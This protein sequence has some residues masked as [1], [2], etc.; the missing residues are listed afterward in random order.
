MAGPPCSLFVFMSSSI[1][2]RS[3]N[4]ETGDETNYKVRMANHIVRNYLEALSA[5]KRNGRLLWSVTEQPVSSHMPKLDE[6]KEFITRHG[7]DYELT[8]MGSYGHELLKPTHLYGDLP[9]LDMMA[10]T[11]PTNFKKSAQIENYY[12]KDSKGRVSGAKL[13]PSSAEYPAKFC[14]ALFDAWKHAF[15]FRPKA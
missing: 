3:S 1:H 8:F 6:F 11:R 13:L 12:Y 5:V 2:M 10:R 4:D 7:I 9:T 14:K 15:S